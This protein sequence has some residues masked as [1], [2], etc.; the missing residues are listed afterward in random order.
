MDP[1]LNELTANR[2]IILDKLITCL[3]DN[4]NIPYP[5]QVIHPDAPLFGSGLGLDSIDALEV[6]LAVENQF[7]IAL[8]ESDITTMRTLNTL[9]DTICLA[10]QEPLPEAEQR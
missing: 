2:Q 8:N 6:V 7:G 10:T 4:L 9:A 1:E 3:K 5:P